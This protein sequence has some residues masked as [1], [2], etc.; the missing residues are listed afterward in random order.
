MKKSLIRAKVNE[1]LQ[2]I[3]FHR[4]STDKQKILFTFY[5]L[6]LVTPTIYCSFNVQIVKKKNI[7]TYL[8]LMFT[9]VNE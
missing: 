8:A 5:L 6:S 1:D 4:Q 2:Y 9:L 7:K 3:L